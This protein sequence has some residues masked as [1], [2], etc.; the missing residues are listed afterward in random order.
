MLIELKCGYLSCRGGNHEE[1]LTMSTTETLRTVIDQLNHEIQELKVENAKLK[2]SQSP[3]ELAI[4]INQQ[5]NSYEEGWRNYVDDFM[6]Q[7][8]RN[9]ML[10]QG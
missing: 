5:W 8:K 6:S 7:S 10:V 2:A 3:T 4:W 9:R 1:F